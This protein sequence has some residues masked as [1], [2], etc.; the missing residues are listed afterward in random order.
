M[1]VY[2]YIYIYTTIPLFV[3][4]NIRRLIASLG[5]CAGR[6]GRYLV[7]RGT[8]HVYSANSCSLATGTDLVYEV[9]LSTKLE[10]LFLRFLISAWHMV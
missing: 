8:L 5:C 9:A 7:R 4:V 1:C 3:A 2:I 6:A 10:R